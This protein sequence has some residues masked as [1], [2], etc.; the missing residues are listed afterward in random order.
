MY[1][2]Q[3]RGFSE[4]RFC[5]LAASEMHPWKDTLKKNT[6]IFIPAAA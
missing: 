4:P 6:H 3:L 5:F 1:I 2:N